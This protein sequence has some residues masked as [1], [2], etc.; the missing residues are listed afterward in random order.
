M[1]K[2]ILVVVLVFVLGAAVAAPTITP[3]CSDASTQ[4]CA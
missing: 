3:L 1:K 2:A 4:P